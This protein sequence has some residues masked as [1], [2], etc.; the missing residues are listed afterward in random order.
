MRLK[1]SENANRLDLDDMSILT[2]S[3]LK[4]QL[5]EAKT[6][7]FIEAIDVYD[8]PLYEIDTTRHHVTEYVTGFVQSQLIKKLVGETCRS[9]LNYPNL[10]LGRVTVD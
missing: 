2:V 9:L 8:F 1:A 7:L 6:D 10:W 5:V 3:S 4:K